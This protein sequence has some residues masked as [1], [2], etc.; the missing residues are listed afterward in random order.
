MAGHSISQNDA[1]FKQERI[2]VSLKKL[3]NQLKETA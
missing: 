3:T 1:M 2:D